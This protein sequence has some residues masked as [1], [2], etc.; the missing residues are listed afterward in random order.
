MPQPAFGVCASTKMPTNRHLLPLAL[1]LTTGTL[2]LT[3]ATEW[4]G[5]R[6]PDGQGHAS[7]SGLPARWSESQNVAWKT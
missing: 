7:G 2:T 4:P 6:G 3:A 1:A 5:W